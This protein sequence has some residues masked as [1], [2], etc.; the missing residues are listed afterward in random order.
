M[1]KHLKGISNVVVNSGSP[2]GRTV[3]FGGAV[4]VSVGWSGPG[5]RFDQVGRDTA[6]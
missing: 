4:G 5:Q 3:G 2:S 1:T 6:A